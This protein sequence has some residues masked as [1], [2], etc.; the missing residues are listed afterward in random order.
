MEFLLR[1]TRWVDALTDRCA[2]I[3]KWAVVAS[4]AISALNAFSRF[5][6]SISSN[7]WLEI[8][9][10]LFAACVMMGAAQV[11][12]VNEHV[13]V[14]IFYGPVSS[15]RKVFIDLFG[16]CI[17]LLP[18]M[19]FLLLMSWPFFTQM[20][21]S[22]EMSQSAGGLIRWPAALLLPLGFTL[23]LLQGL[24]EIVKRIAWLMN[25]LDMNLHYERPLQ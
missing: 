6:F 3:A 17:F 4:C 1:C 21:L 7:A 13:R 24:A 11:L 2:T 25:K 12:R 20:F 8:Q 22:G 23:I 19:G 18:S 10:Y 16:L 9:W 14:D 5:F 15:R